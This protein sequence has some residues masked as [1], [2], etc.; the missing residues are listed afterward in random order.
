MQN[1]RVGLKP[2]CPFTKDLRESLPILIILARKL[3]KNIFEDFAETL[4]KEISEDPALALSPVTDKVK[5]VLSPGGRPVDFLYFKDLLDYLKK[6]NLDHTWGEASVAGI[7]C[8]LGIFPVWVPREGC[9]VQDFRCFFEVCREVWGKPTFLG[10][11]L[12]VDR[13]VDISGCEVRKVHVEKV[14][15]ERKTRWQREAFFLKRWDRPLLKYELTGVPWDKLDDMQDCRCFLH[16]RNTDTHWEIGEE[17]DV[18]IRKPCRVIGFG[19][20]PS[21]SEVR[22]K[23]TCSIYMLN[24]VE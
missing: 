13:G 18:P 9:E 10:A 1:R 20:P 11:H 14:D 5:E 23:K 17:T 15:H 22:E 7:L 16:A 4:S 8:Q 24:D 3:A 2:A 21:W 12:V 19:S 6:H